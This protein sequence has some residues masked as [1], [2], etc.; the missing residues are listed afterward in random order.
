MNNKR[1]RPGASNRTPSRPST[2][3]NLAQHGR[4]RS[5]LEYQDDEESQPLKGGKRRIEDDDED[6][7]EDGMDY[8]DDEGG[9]HDRPSLE[10]GPFLDRSGGQ[11]NDSLAEQ[12]RKRRIADRS[13][14]SSLRD[15]WR[16]AREALPILTLSLFSLMLSG[17]LLIHLARWP[18]FVKVDKLFILIPIL[19]NLKGNLEMNLSLRL[20]TSANIGELDVRRTRQALVAGNLALLQVQALI[21]STFAG[22]LAFMLGL[23]L[24]T[25]SSEP[26]KQPQPTAPRAALLDMAS[27]L[28]GR[29]AKRRII[30]GH[31]KPPADPSAKLRNGYFEFVLV[32]A[33]GTLSASLSSAIL[34]S[35]MCTLVIMSRQ[36]NVNPDNVAAPIAASLGDLLTLVLMGLIGSFLVRFEGT[37][38]ATIIF[39]VLIAFCLACFTITW[40]NFYVKQLLSSGWTPLL[41]AI[42]ISSGAGMVLDSFVQKYDGFALLAPVITGLP[43]AC[44][45]IFASRI[46]TALHSS[47]GVHGAVA[48]AKLHHSQQQGHPHA[49]GSHGKKGQLRFWLTPVEGWLVPVTLA[50]IG[51]SIATVYISMVWWTQQMSFGWVF[52]ASFVAVACIAVLVALAL[53]HFICLYLWT[54]DFDPGEWPRG[55][56]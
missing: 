38:L 4:E 21:V 19:L 14:A 2:S 36:L 16:I 39:G 7:S 35:F 11:H 10:A 30:H 47:E 5:S 26:V 22:T 8:V 41:V 1:E 49:S 32:L 9:H 43:G 3:T 50:F 13:C 44:T 40:R 53:S 12:R 28:G 37:I 33:T 24:P 29:L 18:V 27:R 6:R 46:S 15:V 34:G 54:R 56:C 17:E 20:S 48:L 45:A 42:V 52:W 51:A 25:Q 55:R 31:P 23:I